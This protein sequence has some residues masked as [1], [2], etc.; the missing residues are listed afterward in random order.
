MVDNSQKGYTIP[1]HLSSGR[2]VEMDAFDSLPESWRR[3]IRE[4]SIVVSVEN[5]LSMLPLDL[6]HVGIGYSTVKRQIKDTVPRAYFDPWGRDADYL[7][8]I[9]R[10]ARLRELEAQLFVREDELTY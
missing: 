9:H 8:R 6:I 5:L 3:M 2:K 4:A 7:Y 1:N 10:E